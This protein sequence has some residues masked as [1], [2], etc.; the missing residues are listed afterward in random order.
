MDPLLAAGDHGGPP[1]LP[2]LTPP[3]SIDNSVK[4]STSTGSG[5]VAT[6]V[7][8]G[9]PPIQ[10]K[11][12][13]RIRRW[14]FIDLASLLADPTH[15]PEEVAVPSVN[16]QVVIVQSLDQLH[17]KKKSI[18]DLTSW[19]QAFTVL[20][21]AISSYDKSTKEE[22]S[23]LLAYSHLI[24]QLSKDLKAGFTVAAV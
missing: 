9:I 6:V 3:V 22:I 10:T 17:R 8:E 12:L 23:G 11:V 20:M 4:S 18:S 5:N 1:L 7:A 16:H 2:T 14:E 13:E 24:I 21:A 19:L 15:K